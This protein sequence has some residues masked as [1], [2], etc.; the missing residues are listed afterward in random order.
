M[1]PTEAVVFIPDDVE[2]NEGLYA[3]RGIAHIERRGHRFVGV[4][5]NAERV[6]RLA[7]AGIVVVF[8]HRAHSASLPTEGIKR[9][10]VGEETCRLVPIVQESAPY[11]SNS[12]SP[13][14]PVGQHY[15][16]AAPFDESP[17]VVILERQ[18]AAAKWHNGRVPAA[19]VVE[20]AA[21]RWG[22][23]PTPN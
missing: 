15:G 11:R 20:Q 12:A 5:R 6:M 19:D 4:M 21:R 17:T 14:R 2:C 22:F 10:W 8:A 1:S 16:L 23:H 18:R 13:P 9:E 7:R 3:R